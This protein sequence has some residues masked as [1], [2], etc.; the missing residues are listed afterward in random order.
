MDT[1]SF[2]QTN[3][4]Q[5][6]S[7]G[8]NSFQWQDGTAL[9]GKIRISCTRTKSLRC[10]KRLVTGSKITGKSV[11]RRK[12]TS[13][14][15]SFT[16]IGQTFYISKGRKLSLSFQM[17]P[18]SQSPNKKTWVCESRESK[19]VKGKKAFQEDVVRL[20]SDRKKTKTRS[21]LLSDAV[22]DFDQIS[23]RSL[24]NFLKFIMSW[25]LYFCH[26]CNQRNL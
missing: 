11:T 9:N 2:N 14:L 10:G 4:S 19:A 26:I 16:N 6:R 20:K 1:H 18:N 13:T 24:F 15:T 21:L 25:H 22:L 8:L 5:F 7:I 23:S 17:V 12:F 3:E